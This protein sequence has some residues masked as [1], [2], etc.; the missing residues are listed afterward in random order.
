MYFVQRQNDVII[1]LYR[2]AQPFAMEVLEIDHP[3]V[4]AFLNPL[5][6]PIAPPS[7]ISDR[8]FFQALALRGM[9]TFN[10]ALLCVRTGELPMAFQSFL[11]T[12]T[13]EQE[14]SARMLLSG[15]VIFE[16]DHPLTK[17]FGDWYGMSPENI[18]E[19]WLEASNL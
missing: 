11:Q 13:S 15:A 8:Q 10:E 2:N 1:G 14:F 9:L 18:D 6:L 4:V 7:K 16:R 3:D 19:L 17:A 5:P 12:L